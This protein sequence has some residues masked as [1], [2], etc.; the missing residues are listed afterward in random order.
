MKRLI[1]ACGLVGSIAAAQAQPAH[2][3]VFDAQQRATQLQKGLQLTD[4]QTAKV[5]TIFENAGQQHK[6]LMDK[7]KP[8]LD[9]F[10]ADQK[11]L[12]EQTQQQISGVLTPKQLVALKQYHDMHGSMHKHRHDHADMA[13]DES[14]ADHPAAK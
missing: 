2:H 12:H 14:H 13:G 3:E 4:E 11:A 8:Q 5:K 10:R 6:A 9:A 1:L 7:Y